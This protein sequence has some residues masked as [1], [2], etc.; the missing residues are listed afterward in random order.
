MT[1][2][3]HLTNQPPAE[4]ATPQPRFLVNWLLLWQLVF[5]LLSV[6]CQHFENAAFLDGVSGFFCDGN[7]CRILWWISM[8]AIISSVCVCVS[9][10]ACAEIALLVPP[11]FQ[12]VWD[13]CYLRF[14]IIMNLVCV[15]DQSIWV[16]GARHWPSQ[17]HLITQPL[18]PDQRP[19]LAGYCSLIISSFI[20]TKWCLTNLTL[21]LQKSSLCCVSALRCWP[22]PERSLWSADQC[23][24]VAVYACATSVLL[25][26]L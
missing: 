4:G 1:E 2:R 15:Q 11:L 9:A 12:R 19:H 5:L 25:W 20:L 18:V 16:G 13:E 14:S 3:K 26:Q 7:Y 8:H 24:L 10:C 6:V 22:P 23:H 17:L 21:A